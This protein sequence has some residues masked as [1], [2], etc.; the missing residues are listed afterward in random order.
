MPHHIVY[1]PADRPEREALVDGRWVPAEIRMWTQ[2]DD[3]TWSADVGYSMA[4][5]ENRIGTFTADRLRALGG[6]AFGV[7]L[8]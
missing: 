5:A 2:H 6:A 1:K 3:E 8:E 7:G 4:P